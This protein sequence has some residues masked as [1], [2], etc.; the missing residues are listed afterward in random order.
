MF[1]YRIFAI[2]SQVV[3]KL[4]LV[5][6]RWAEMG[7]TKQSRGWGQRSDLRFQISEGRRADRL[8]GEEVRRVRKV[9]K[10]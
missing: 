8:G 3:F 1:N 6:F 10:V 5:F 9:R 4:F 7:R 2:L